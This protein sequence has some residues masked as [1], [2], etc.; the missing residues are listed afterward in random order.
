[1]KTMSRDQD[2][3]TRAKVTLTFGFDP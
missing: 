3:V 1:M 2:M